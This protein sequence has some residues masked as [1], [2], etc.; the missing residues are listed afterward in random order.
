MLLLWKARKCLWLPISTI[1]YLFIRS[2]ASA[3]KYAPPLDLRVELF[4]GLVDRHKV[5]FHRWVSLVGK[6]SSL[7]AMP[8]LPASRCECISVCT[9]IGFSNHLWL[10][11]LSNCRK[12][13][14]R[15]CARVPSITL[16]SPIFMQSST[17]TY[18]G[19][20]LFLLLEKRILFCEPSRLIR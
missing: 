14:R 20:S 1:R 3:L 16:T 18:L 6:S 19:W 5:L 15:I 7:S 8:R 4:V 12:H 17:N 9:E 13:S 11:R 10:M 2:L